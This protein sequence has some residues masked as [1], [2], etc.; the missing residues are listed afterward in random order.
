MHHQSQGVNEQLRRY[1]HGTAG[2]HQRGMQ[3]QAA[4]C[5]QHMM[6]EHRVRDD[7]RMGLLEKHIASMHQCFRHRG[8]D[9]IQSAMREAAEQL[10]GQHSEMLGQ[11]TQCI[12]GNLGETVRNM[13]T[14]SGQHMDGMYDLLHQNQAAT[15]AQN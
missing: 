7:N 10:N 12:T 8:A 11:F 5:G 13:Q 14:Q 2:R 15:S 4:E 6:M 3:E 1:L 9:E